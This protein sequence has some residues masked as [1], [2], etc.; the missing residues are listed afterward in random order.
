VATSYGV[1]Q[2]G[3]DANNSSTEVVTLLHCS[4]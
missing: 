4:G 1:G 2:Q 3:C